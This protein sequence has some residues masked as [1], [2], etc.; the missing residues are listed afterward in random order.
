MDCVRTRSVTRRGVRA[1]RAGGIDL[2]RVN[3]Y[4]SIDKVPPGSMVNIRN[5]MY[6]VSEGLRFMSKDRA[7]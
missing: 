1:R 7:R 3:Q 5:D 2:A 4:H 6:L